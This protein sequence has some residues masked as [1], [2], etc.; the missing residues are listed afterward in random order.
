M[1]NRSSFCLIKVEVPQPATFLEVKIRKNCDN[2]EFHST[3]EKIVKINNSKNL[4]YRNR[5]NFL[6]LFSKR[7]LQSIQLKY[8]AFMKKK[9]NLFID[10]L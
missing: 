7:I 8:H 4:F 10:Q 6:L 2:I 1:L 3:H 5:I 9:L